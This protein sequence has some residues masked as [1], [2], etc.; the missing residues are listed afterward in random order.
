M[1]VI[2]ADAT[3]A[4][5]AGHV[6]RMA[7][8]IARWRASGGG[9]VWLDGRVDI[10]FVRSHL[11]SLGLGAAEG[12]HRATVLIVDSYDPAV[13][14]KG[15]STGNYALRVLVDDV[16]GI[17][18]PGYD[19]VWNPNAYSAAGLYPAFGG[20]IIGGPDSVPLRTDLPR[21]VEGTGSRIGVMLGG[22]PPPE[23]F[24]ES[25]IVLSRRRTDWQFAAPS[26]WAPDGWLKIAPDA[27]WTDLNLCSRLLTAGGSTVWEAAAVGIPVVIAVIADNQRRVADWAAEANVP[28]MDARS[29]EDPGSL[30]E[31]SLARAKKLP[32][33]DGRA[34][35]VISRLRSSVRQALT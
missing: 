23:K 11:T 34:S 15:A 33:V 28:V 24:L 1:L 7:S 16:G 10:P 14:V 31:A 35:A 29:P 25:L 22:G 18:P 3:A 17:V 32:A 30:V 6:M 9:E 8:F 12:S 4:T 5:G 13:R 19:I 26:M 20:E 2:R 21:W 27:P